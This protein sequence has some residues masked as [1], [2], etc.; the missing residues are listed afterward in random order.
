MGLTAPKKNRRGKRASP[1]AA[2]ATITAADLSS[3]LDYGKSALHAT[4]RLAHALHASRKV[5]P[6]SPA[7]A[8]SSAPAKR[9]S[10]KGTALSG[11][12]WHPAKITDAQEIFQ[13]TGDTV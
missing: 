5:A 11:R 3:A 4:V 9:S 12:G 1:V 13:G 2:P 8:P 10:S 7:K 6:A